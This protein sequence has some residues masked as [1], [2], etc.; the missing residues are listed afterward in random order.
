MY[1]SDEPP[2]NEDDPIVRSPTKYD[3][4]EL[5]EQITD[6]HLHEEIDFG[7]LVGSEVW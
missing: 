1:F 7:P 6:E 3:I 5:V 2:M 4:E